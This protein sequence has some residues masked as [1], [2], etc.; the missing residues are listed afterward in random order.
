M[1]KTLNGKWMF[2]QAG[3]TGWYDAEV[4]GCNFTDLMKNGLIDDLFYGLNEK[5]CEFVGKSDWEYSREFELSENDI[6]CD[7]VFLCFEMLDTLAEIY[8]NG[9]LADREDNC[10]VEI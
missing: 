2:R 8:I 5:E 6:N 9:K 7:E 4:S 10:Y 1:K 3:K